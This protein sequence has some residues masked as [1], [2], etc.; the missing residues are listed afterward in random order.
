MINYIV[1]RFIYM[2]VV[3]LL[4]SV[5]AFIVIQL[6]PGSYLQSIVSQLKQRGV[7]VTADYEEE[8][9]R[10]YGFNLP[11]YRQYLNWLGNIVFR[12]DFGRSFVHNRTVLSMMGER[13]VLTIVLS[14]STLIATY[15]MA[16]PIAIYSATHQYSIWDYFWTFFGFIGLATPNFLLALVLMFSFYRLGMD[17]GGL[18][19][20]EFQMMEGWNLAKV[21]DM[22]KHLP[23]PIIVV[24]TAGTA[25]LIRVLRGSLLD[26]LSKAYVVTARAKGLNETRLLFRYP[27]RIAVNPIISQIGGILPQLISGATITSIV[28]NLPTTGPL[29]LQALRQQDLYVAASI[30]LMLSTL[31]VIGVLISDILLAIV[32][33]RIRFERAS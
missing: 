29:L 2:V 4:I 21:W 26:E 15:L 16:I 3:I 7:Q 31:G 9:A 10:Q 25:G 24:G 23:I 33:P 30:L 1:R 8:L 19:S 11:V 13:I 17:V 28:L 18:F 14:F 32:D 27:V 5:V 22:V 12:G 6:P 20:L